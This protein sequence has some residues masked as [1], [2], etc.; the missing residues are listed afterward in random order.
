VYKPE[1]RTYVFIVLPC[2][3]CSKKATEM[4]ERVLSAHKQSPVDWPVMREIEN[5]LKGGKVIEHP[6]C[7]DNFADF[8]GIKERRRT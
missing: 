6:N 7:Y 4:L 5:F 1:S 8:L 2:V 3:A